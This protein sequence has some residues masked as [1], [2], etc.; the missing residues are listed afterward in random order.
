MMSQLSLV[1]VH[2]LTHSNDEGTSYLQNQSVVTFKHSV[3]KMVI[4]GYTLMRRTVRDHYTILL[5]V[6]LNISKTIVLRQE[7][8]NTGGV[9][10]H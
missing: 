5:K 4:F 1:S 6:F 3:N 7:L 9:L 10:W 8:D 2:P